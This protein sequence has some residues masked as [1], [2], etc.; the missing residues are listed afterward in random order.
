[1]TYSIKSPKGADFADIAVHVDLLQIGNISPFKCASPR[2]TPAHEHLKGF[3]QDG[4]FRPIS[5]REEI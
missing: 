3:L 2:L 5:T 4:S 1:M